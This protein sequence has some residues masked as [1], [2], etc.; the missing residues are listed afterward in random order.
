[1]KKVVANNADL[2]IIPLKNHVGTGIGKRYR[3]F[4]EVARRP[5]G[6]TAKD[7]ATL[8]NMSKHSLWYLISPLRKNGSIVATGE[9]RNGCMEVVCRV[10][11][12]KLDAMRMEMQCVLE[13]MDAIIAEKIKEVR[14]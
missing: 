2:T 3:L 1:M 10:S 5:N 14:K 9:T 8:F 4:L 13:M 12:Q 11:P 6:I 7:L